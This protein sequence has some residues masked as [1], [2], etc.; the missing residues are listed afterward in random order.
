MVE[1]KAFGKT[2]VYTDKDGKVKELEVIIKNAK[3]AVRKRFIMEQAT[4]TKEVMKELCMLKNVEH[5]PKE[6]Y[7]VLGVAD[8]IDG[9]YDKRVQDVQWHISYFNDKDKEQIEKVMERAGCTNY[10][11]YQSID[12]CIE[13]FKK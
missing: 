3:E 7:S 8:Y 6:C 12:E 13:S 11:L 5:L 2:N 4:K 1:E 9:G 10:Q